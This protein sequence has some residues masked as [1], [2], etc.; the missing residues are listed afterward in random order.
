M[1]RTIKIALILGLVTFLIDLIPFLLVNIPLVGL[2]GILGLLCFSGMVTY[3]FW[4][5]NRYSSTDYRLALE[6]VFLFGIW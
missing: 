1:D 3:L 2:A 6:S 4:F 5:L